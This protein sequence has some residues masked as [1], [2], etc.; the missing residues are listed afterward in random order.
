[1]CFIYTSA[2]RLRRSGM[3]EDILFLLWWVPEN[4]IIYGR[5]VEIL[6]DPSNPRRYSF[7]SFAGG[8]ND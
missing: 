7:D 5:E 4:A 3:L 2:L 8:R 6:S 1:M